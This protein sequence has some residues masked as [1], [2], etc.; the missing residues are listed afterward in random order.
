MQ[1]TH[2]EPRTHEKNVRVAR[3]Q[4]ARCGVLFTECAGPIWQ[5][6]GR[7]PPSVGEENLACGATMRI[8]GT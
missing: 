7:H 8:E 5:A 4:C 6:S 3:V 2:L 1:L